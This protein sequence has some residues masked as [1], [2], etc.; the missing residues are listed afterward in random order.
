MNEFPGLTDSFIRA[1]CVPREGSHATGTTARADAMLAD[2][3]ELAAASIHTAAIVGDVAAVASF[4]A[5]DRTLATAKAG[6]YHWDPLTHLCFSNYLKCDPSRSDAFVATATAL[7]SAGASANTGWLEAEHQPRP[8][9]ESALYGAAGVAHHPALTALLIAHGAD[10]NDIEV[11]YH[12]PESYDNRA[13]ELL[14][15]TGALTAESLAWMLVRKHDWHDIDGARLLL[16]HGADPNLAVAHVNTALLHALA[17]NNSLE[18]IALLLDHGADPRIVARGYNGFAAAARTGRGDVLTLFAERGFV[19]E[20]EGVDRLIAA[21]AGDEGAAAHAIAE[22]EPELLAEV[23]AMGGDLLARFAGTN[24]RAGVARLLDLGVPVAAPFTAGDAY[25]DE[26]RG[27]LAI[28]VAA[29]RGRPEV[30]R[31]L[32]E[33]GSP[34]DLPDANGR[35]PLALAIRACVDSYWSARRTTESIVALLAAGA[36]TAGVTLPT[37]YPEAD[38]LLAGQTSA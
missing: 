36:T 13:L 37:G 16:T 20:L 30:V 1:A 28:H 15:A 9:W 21:C 24:N 26:P 11:V 22:A 29:W 27:S 6:P 3:P 38:L 17:R 12:T 19:P 18:M 35:T 10:V 2:H 32:L 5:A 14:L 7:L 31:L 34:V 23:L 25:F 8:E 4:L 33:R